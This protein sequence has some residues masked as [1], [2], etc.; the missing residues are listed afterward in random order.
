MLAKLENLYL[1]IL[2]LVTL[3]IATL[4]LVAFAFAVFNARGIASTLLPSPP[5]PI[6]RDDIT[7]ENYLGEVHPAESTQQSAT[8]NAVADAALPLRSA[9]R[10]LAE[11]FRR[12]VCRGNCYGTDEN[13]DAR[14]ERQLEE[15]RD[16]FDAAYHSDY[17]ASIL[18]FATA[19]NASTD[20]RLNDD[21]FSEAMLWH[22][23]RF[24]SI[25]SGVQFERDFERQRAVA[26]AW[27]AALSLATFL[28][29]IFFFV[30]VKIER[31]LR[32]VR[33]QSADSIPPT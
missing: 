19:L 3:A 23:A 12:V 1:D 24:R 26:S 8:G 16:G 28:I 29:V 4:A 20:R 31:N 27:F 14:I 33:T 7:F 30:L 11:Y 5:P 18:A 13:L 15:T 32:V 9:S 25:V 22:D 21:D 2:R 10:Q 6:S 17:E